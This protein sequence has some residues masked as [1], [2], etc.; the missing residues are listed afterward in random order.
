MHLIIFSL[1]AKFEK[2]KVEIDNRRRTRHILQLLGQIE[3]AQSAHSKYVE[4]FLHFER[5]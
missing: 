3:L 1:I 4:V 2:S 5:G